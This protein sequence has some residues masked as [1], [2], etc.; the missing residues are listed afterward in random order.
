MN[1][2]GYGLVV[3]SLLLMSCNDDNGS[4]VVPVEE[5]TSAAIEELRDE[6]TAPAGGWRLQYQPTPDAG[7]FLILLTFKEDGQ[8]TIQSDVVDEN[9]R[10]FEQT[11]P[12]RIDNSLGLELI[13]ETF[14]VF[15]YLF[16]LDQAGFGAEFEF[17]YQKKEG[18]NLLFQSKSD[19]SNPTII[20]LEPADAGAP[21]AFARDIAENLNAYQL[22]SPKALEAV[23][24]IQQV[25]LHDVGIS[26]FWSLDL[27]KRTI[28]ADLAGRGALLEDAIL[29]GGII[30][31]HTT[32]YAFRDGKLV[33][34]E[35]LSFALD[36]QQVTISEINLNAFDLSGPALCP[37]GEAD[38]PEYTG[39]AAGLGDVTLQKSFLSSS[40]RNFRN[41]NL[42]SINA[43]FLFDGA[44]VSLA[45]DGIISETF[46]NALGFLFLYG[47]EGLDPAIP[48]FSLGLILDNGEEA[49]RL[50]LRAFEPTETQVNRIKIQFT[51]AFY[52]SDAPNA[53]EEE[54]LIAVTDEI[55]E[56]GELYVYSFPAAGPGVYRL[57]NPCNGYEVFLVQ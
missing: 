39:Q 6:L 31:R 28:T 1:K 42:F 2:L 38:S 19:R 47:P 4:S 48:S 50:L 25:I 51:G 22:L 12:Y 35:P 49:D 10:F 33:L 14:G 30:L 34:M 23:A 21:A 17:I 41:G 8:V 27:A 57:F 11:I 15:H 36:E 54:N 18:G 45:E 20:T 7:I 24:P 43:P 46:P 32:G 13:F 56:G 29:N 37:G 40:G 16:E 3:W 53:G 44:G 5:R 26:V 55:F 52:Y 9:G